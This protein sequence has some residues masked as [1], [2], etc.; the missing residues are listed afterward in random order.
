MFPILGL[1]MTKEAAPAKYQKISA[2]EDANL[3]HM[4]VYVYYLKCF[5]G[6]EYI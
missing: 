4:Y 3:W 6:A 1:K 2:L 5:M